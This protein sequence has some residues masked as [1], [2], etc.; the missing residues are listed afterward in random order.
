[1]MNVAVVMGNTTEPT[2]LA[3][4]DGHLKVGGAG[5]VAPNRPG[6]SALRAGPQ[7]SRVWGA[8]R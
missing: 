2:D 1:L 3:P 6:V 7:R 8:R 5:P 4:N